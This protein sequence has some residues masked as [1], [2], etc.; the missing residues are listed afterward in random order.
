MYLLCKKASFY[1][2][3]SLAPR[4]T[5]KLDDYTLSAICNCLFNIFAATFHK[6]DLSSFRNTRVQIA[7]VL[8]LLPMVCPMFVVGNFKDSTDTAEIFYV[9][10]LEKQLVS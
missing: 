4:L 2:E 8:G 10:F 6:R 9:L 5:P 3:D 1:S 7:V